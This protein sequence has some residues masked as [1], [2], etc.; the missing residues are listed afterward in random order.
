MKDRGPE[1]RHS[2][3][4]KQSLKIRFKKLFRTRISFT[5][6]RSIFQKCRNPMLKNF[7]WYIQNS[8]IG[9]WGTQSVIKKEQHINTRIFFDCLVE[10]K[11]FSRPKIL[12]KHYIIPL[13]NCIYLLGIL[14]YND[15]VVICLKKI[16]KTR[17]ICAV[18][19]VLIVC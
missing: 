8:K 7:P 6:Q 3:A 18:F 9:F 5:I 11:S 1:I 15:K 4:H 17:F 12:M 13:K 14:C 2:G 19:I 16:S 10:K